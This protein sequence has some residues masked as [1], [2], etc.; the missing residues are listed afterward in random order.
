MLFRSVGG[1]GNDTLDGGLLID[2]MRGG[3]GNDSYVVNSRYD[4]VDETSDGV[5]DAGGIDVVRSLAPVYTLANFVENLVLGG[6]GNISGTGNDKANLI[7]GNNGSNAINGGLGADII[8]GGLGNDLLTGGAGADTFVFNTALDAATNL[9]TIKD[10][11]VNGAGDKIQLDDDI[12]LALGPVTST[13]A[14][15]PI[16]RAHV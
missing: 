2:T 10:W 15:D 3:A 5:N 6:T 4:V 11:D 8:K 13:T 1:L 9:D 14:L 12:F 7:T 16:G